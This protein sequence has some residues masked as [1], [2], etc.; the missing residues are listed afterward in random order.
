MA[1]G[2][3]K[4]MQCCGNSA[5][6]DEKRKTMRDLL[7]NEIPVARK[8]SIWLMKNGKMKVG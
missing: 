8:E 7:V 1:K 6:D 4:S 3:T 2:R 5:G